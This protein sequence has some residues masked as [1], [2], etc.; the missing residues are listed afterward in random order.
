MR[1]RRRMRGQPPW[2]NERDSDCCSRRHIRSCNSASH[3][4][5]QAASAKPCTTTSRAVLAA[6]RQ[7]QQR[8]GPTR[9]NR[10]VRGAPILQL[11]SPP[12]PGA[13]RRLRGP[14]HLCGTGTPPWA[15]GTA[16]TSGC[17]DYPQKPRGIVPWAAGL[18]TGRAIPAMGRGLR[19]LLLAGALAIAA[20]AAA[21]PAELCD[22]LG[23]PRKRCGEW[24]RPRLRYGAE[25]RPLRLPP[26]SALPHLDRHCSNWCMATRCWSGL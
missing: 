22:D 20:R 23:G 14:T 21:P 17:S 16:G 19:L 10:R 6:A 25:S 8:G 5:A 18:P 9:P 2:R 24:L 1:Q 13:L 7:A 3:A 15:P 26:L 4:D 11:A 12:H